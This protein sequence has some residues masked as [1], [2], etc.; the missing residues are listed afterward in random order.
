MYRSGRCRYLSRLFAATGI[1]TVAVL[2]VGG[3][4]SP[5]S[6]SVSSTTA[7][8]TTD[9]ATNRD[10]DDLGVGAYRGCGTVQVGYGPRGIAV[11]A[12]LHRAYVVTQDPATPPYPVSVTVLDTRTHAA[13]TT[14]PVNDVFVRETQPLVIDP[15]THLVYLLSVG[16]RGTLAVID[17]ATDSVNAYIP[18]GDHSDPSA[19]AL[20]SDRHRLYVAESAGVAGDCRRARPTSQGVGCDGNAS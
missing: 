13:I 5:A 2:A 18:V 7:P 20:D 17:P 8:T 16:A 12:G 9:P 11:D 3:C 15:V 6:V 19:V 4:G 14:I 10:F 1:A